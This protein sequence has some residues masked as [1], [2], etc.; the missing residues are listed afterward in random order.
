M[1]AARGQ[2]QERRD[3][4]AAP[5]RAA[6]GESVTGEGRRQAAMQATVLRRG[7]RIVE[8]APYND[9]DGEDCVQLY[10]AYIVQAPNGLS[11]LATAASAR[12]NRMNGSPRTSRPG[13][14]GAVQGDHH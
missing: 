6:H 7:G 1:R 8:G 5:P 11:I 13:A 12:G 14:G 10:I 2:Q 4:D 9:A 3:R